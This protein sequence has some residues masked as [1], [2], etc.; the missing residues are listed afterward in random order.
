MGA[1]RESHKETPFRNQRLQL[2]ET[3]PDVF[4]ALRGRGTAGV[5]VFLVFLIKQLL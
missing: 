1:Q 5:S 2:G 4:L 3:Q